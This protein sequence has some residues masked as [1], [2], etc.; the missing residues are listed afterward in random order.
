MSAIRILQTL[1]TGY[2]DG[3]K[4]AVLVP[5][6]GKQIRLLK[7]K[8]L[9]KSGGAIDVGIC[10]KL[11]NGSWKFFTWVQL[12]AP[13][14]TDVTAAI[15]AGTTTDLTTLTANDGYV[16]QS[17]KKFNIIGLNVSQAP[18]ANQVFEYKYWNGASWASLTTIAVPTYATTERLVVFLAPIDWAVGGGDGLSDSLY[19]VRVRATT[20][21]DT[22]RAQ[23]NL[24]WVGQFI[25]F[26]YQV[27]NNTA[28]EFVVPANDPPLLFET[29]EGLMP[30]FGGA[31]AANCV[32]A[33]YLIQD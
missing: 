20:P 32:Q 23:A 33:Q 16:V 9:N 30:Y 22:T 1:H 13:K 3:A 6:T 7:A 11:A 31:N 12:G 21:P 5:S 24:A 29:L 17:A 4:S 15:Q 26:Q 8:A 19:A 14:A 25:D 10:R 2:P 28:F 27:A 18:T